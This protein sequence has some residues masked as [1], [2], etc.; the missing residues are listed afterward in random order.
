M[1]QPMLTGH[2]RWSGAD[3]AGERTTPAMPLSI[4]LA[5]Q[6]PQRVALIARLGLEVAVQPSGVDEAAVAVPADPAGQVLAL[7]RAKAEAVA[8]CRPEALVLGA[9]TLVALDREVLGKPD[10]P[11]AATAMLRRLAGRRH[12]VLTGVALIVPAGAAL[13]AGTRRSLDS[14]GAMP[15]AGGPALRLHRGPDGEGHTL[16]AVVSSTVTFRPLAADQIAA[17]VQTGE[18]L[19][20]AGA[21]GIQGAGSRLVAS[22]AG[23][24]TNVV[25]LPLCAVAALLQAGTGRSIPCPGDPACRMEGAEGCLCWQVPPPAR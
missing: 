7:A 15:W 19:D 25:G 10:S 24:F 22:L 18:P 2:S 11:E 23:C 21:Y 6:S 20:K 12:A 9:D 4:T 8:R 13:P 17:Y 5:S 3:F 16:T 1:V 14:A